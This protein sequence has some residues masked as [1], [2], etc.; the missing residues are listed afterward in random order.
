MKKLFVILIGL[1][2]TAFIHPLMAVNF[3]KVDNLFEYILKGQGEKYD[4]TRLDLSEKNLA[5]FR[6]EVEYADQL[7]KTIFGE[8][9]DAYEAYFRSFIAVN[10]EPFKT[11]ITTLCT[12][13]KMKPDS[14]K[15]LADNKMMYRLQLSKNL[16]V[17]GRAILASIDK[18]GYPVTSKYRMTMVDMIFNTQY[19]DLLTAPTLDKY[20][21]FLSDWPQSDKI[22]SVKQNYDDVL[23]QQSITDKN[24]DLYLFDNC[25]PNETKRHLVAD[26]W[27]IYGDR[28]AEVTDYEHAAVFYNKS[29]QLGSREGLFKLTVLKYDGKIKSD[30][31][32]LP[33]FE[34]LAASGDN[35]A[36]EY[37]FNIQN[38]TLTL[39]IEGTL[40][41]FLTSKDKL[42]VANITLGGRLNAADLEILGDMS[43][44]GKLVSID[45]SAARLYKIPD[46][47]FAECT[48]LISIKL[49]FITN[50]IGNEAFLN[51][52]RLTDFVLP[53]SVV[54]MVGGAFNGCA[55][56][57]SLTLPATMVRGLG[58]GTFAAGCKRLS[59]IH[60]AI[61][62]PM[63]KSM[64]GVL[65]NKD[66][67]VI[68]RYP[69]GKE[70]SLFSFPNTITEVGIGAFEG[71][72]YLNTVTMTE[73]MKVIRDGAFKGC[74]SISSIAIPSMVNEI[75]GYA[76]ENCS[77]LMTIGLPVFIT[78]INYRTFKGCT[79]LMSIVIPESV[80]EI[81]SEAFAGCIG[82]TSILIPATV[83]GLGEKAFD[84]CV[85]LRE[86]HNKQVT[87]Q[88]VP[89]LFEGVDKATC[90]LF[91]PVGSK[92]AYQQY[93]IWKDFTHITE[94]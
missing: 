77:K 79:S 55:M 47:V 68:L 43:R 94:E 75:G 80:K 49:P 16:V 6:S 1:M 59:N 89:A 61:G 65:Y 74:S 27:A 53:D 40:E 56:L 34:K 37:V 76:F 19:S 14:L 31:D 81:R 48:N 13:F 71:C 54:E 86:I 29:I 3:G 73:A 17:E 87:P 72:S 26:D 67:T 66:A 60:V 70:A 93:P 24:H 4:K 69:A 23:F 85:S 30:E 82:L 7:K 58:F 88:M 52:A 63:Y 42:R 35:R 62:N 32:E 92:L 15:L 41:T 5:A 25:L 33:I 20:R 64:D 2:V 21:A 28:K 10:A 11:N 57:K 22:P 90:T 36:K 46:R 83:K 12:G 50:A 9:M 84:G 91:V 38:R 18:T 39:A 78:E 45:L 44:K 8:P 51:C